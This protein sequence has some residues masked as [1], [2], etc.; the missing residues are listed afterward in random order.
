MRTRHLPRLTLL[1]VLL[2]APAAAVDIHLMGVFSDRAVMALDG[3][4]QV[5][6]VGETSEAGVRLISTDSRSGT[7][8][9]E[10][11]GRQRQ[12]GID[13][14]VGGEFQPR[15]ISQ[16]R[17][18]RGSSGGFT[19]PGAINGHAVTFLVDTGASAIALSAVEA[20]RLGLDYTRGAQVRVQTASG[21][22]WAHRIHLDR[23]RVGG[24][25]QRNVPAFV[26]PGNQPGMA[27][28]GMSFLDQ[29]DMR[30]EGGALILEQRF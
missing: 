20:R 29:V 2:A 10:L 7:V 25:E 28:L 26:L 3:Q 9:I 12:I 21:T 27:L 6:R 15:A 8:L 22:E 19:T 13:G 17:I 18:Y 1:S 23:V 14:R 5:L 16:A 30:N 4:R 24:I 11:E